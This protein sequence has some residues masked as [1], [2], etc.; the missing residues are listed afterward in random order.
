MVLLL[1]IILIRIMYDTLINYIIALFHRKLLHHVLND[2]V[3]VV[4]EFLKV[5][6]EV[7]HY[8]C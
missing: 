8:V 7:M 5:V 4:I 2:A 6:T 1:L 3:G